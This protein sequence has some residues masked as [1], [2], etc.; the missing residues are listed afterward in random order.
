MD[1]SWTQDV[2]VPVLK[3]RRRWLRVC[4]MVFFFVFV[5]LGFAEMVYGNS[6]NSDVNTWIGFGTMMIGLLWGSV[7][8]FLYRE[9]NRGRP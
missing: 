8:E 5:P 9:A 1:T 3:R 6:A 2:V 7:H 4:A